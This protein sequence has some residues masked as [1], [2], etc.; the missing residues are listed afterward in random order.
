VCV[1]ELQPVVVNIRACYRFDL[2]SQ[3]LKP[4][5]PK[6]TQQSNDHEGN[7]FISHVSIVNDLKGNIIT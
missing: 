1:F 3:S 4:L 6:S 2:L 7:C 5:I